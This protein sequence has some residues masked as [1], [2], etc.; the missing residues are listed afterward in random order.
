M[1]CP[2]VCLMGHVWHCYRI[3]DEADLSCLLSIVFLK[4]YAA[5]RNLFTF[6]HGVIGRLGH[7]IVALTRYHF[8]LSLTLLFSKFD[9]CVPTPRLVQN[10]CCFVS[11]GTDL[12]V[13]ITNTCLLKYMFIAI[14]PPKNWKSSDK[15]LWY[16][17]YYCSKHRLWVL[18][19]TSSVRRF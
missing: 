11:K 10:F 16:F 18:V 9:I 14:S 3:V 6:P 15:N 1:F 19:R 2:R 4:M 17:S 13:I 7:V 8:L 5:R 12:K